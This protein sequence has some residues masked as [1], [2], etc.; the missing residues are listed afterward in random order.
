MKMKKVLVTMLA[1]LSFASICSAADTNAKSVV[2]TA[3]QVAAAQAAAEKSKIATAATAEKEKE[4]FFK[5]VQGKT[6]SVSYDSGFK[7]NID[8]PE[9]GVL[10]WTPT[11]G[12]SLA[13]SDNEQYDRQGRLSGQLD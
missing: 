8:Y 6:I 4:A 12:L 1:A 3:E 5:H 10:R 2:P 9:V 11:T 7:F 13:P